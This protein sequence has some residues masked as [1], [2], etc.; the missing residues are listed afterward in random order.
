MPPINPSKNIYTDCSLYLI[1]MLVYLREV[2]DEG[3]FGA[4]PSGDKFWN[5]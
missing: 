1:N 4:T 5:K 2:A 3:S